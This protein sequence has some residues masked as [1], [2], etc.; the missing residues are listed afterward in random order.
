MADEHGEEK[1]ATMAQVKSLVRRKLRKVP[2]HEEQS[3][4]IYPMMDM[5]TILLVFLIQSFA[6]SSGLIGM[7]L[8][9]VSQL[10]ASATVVTGV[11][12]S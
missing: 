5:M 8:P 11:R 4:N 3:L 2:A 6:Q 7:M 10:A 9:E 12:L 1:E